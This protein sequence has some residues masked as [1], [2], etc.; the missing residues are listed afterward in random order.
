MRCLGAT[1]PF[2]RR[3]AAM[4]SVAY[5]FPIICVRPLEFP[6]SHMRLRPLRVRL[7]PHSKH[8]VAF[9]GNKSLI[10][11]WRSFSWFAV[12]CAV[13]WPWSSLALSLFRWWGRFFIVRPPVLPATMRPDRHALQRCYSGQS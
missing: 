9:F 8:V 3:E 4:Q 6:P 10:S 13:K 7:V 1:L 12:F 2:Y 5:C 11:F